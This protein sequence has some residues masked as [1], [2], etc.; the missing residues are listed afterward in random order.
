MSIDEKALRERVDNLSR[1]RYKYYID[2]LSEPGILNT[3]SKYSFSERQLED[4]YACEVTTAR[5][6]KLIDRILARKNKLRKKR[7]YEEVE[8]FINTTVKAPW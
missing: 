1:D 4:L 7:E 5:R 8:E 2:V 6:L 3:I